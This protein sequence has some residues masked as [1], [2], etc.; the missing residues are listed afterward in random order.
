MNHHRSPETAFYFTIAGLLVLALLVTLSPG[1]NPTQLIPKAFASREQAVLQGGTWT[2]YA[3]GDAVQ[4]LAVQ[5]DYLWVGTYLGGLVRWDTRDQTYV[6]YLYPQSGLPSN[7]VRAVDI[8][9][10]GR[11]WVGTD[12]GLAVLSSNGSTIVAHHTGN[13]DLPVDDVTDVG[14]APD[15]K[16]WVA[17]DGGGVSVV[18][19]K[20]TTE[21]LS[22]DEWTVYGLEPL[23]SY[24]VTA[25]DFDEVGN[26]WIGTRPYPN[27]DPQGPPTLGG[28]VCIFDGRSCFTYSPL[29]SSM[30]STRVVTVHAGGGE[31]MWVGTSGGGVTLFRG[32]ESNQTFNKSN[33]GL[34]GNHV[35]AIARDAAGKMWFAVANAGQVGKGVTVLNG[36]FWATLTKTN[37]GLVSNNV[38]AIVADS[39]RRLWFGHRDLCGGVQ[40]VSALAASGQTWTTYD[41]TTSSIPS[42]RISSIAQDTRGDLWF[43]SD[44][45]GVLAYDRTLNRWRPYDQNTTGGG[46]PSNLVRDIAVDQAGRLWMATDSGGSVR[47]RRWTAYTGETTTGGLSNDD[48]HT[49][50]VDATG[51]VW[52]GHSQGIDQLDHQNTP[53]DLSD[54]LWYAFTTELPGLDVRD[55]AWVGGDHMWV[56]TDGGVGVYDGT[57]W[58][59]YRTPDLVSN[60]VQTIFPDSHSGQVWVGTANGASVFDQ[61]TGTWTSYT[62]ANTGGDLVDDNIQAIHVDSW[63]RVWFATSQGVSIKDGDEWSTFTAANS[64]L[65]ANDVTG[66]LVDG[67]GL[68]WLGTHEHGVSVFDSSDWDSFAF[69]DHGL[70][71]NYITDITFGADDSV[72][73]A[74][75]DRGFG[76]L[77]GA[78]WTTYSRASTEDQLASDKVRTIAIDEDSKAW[79]GTLSFISGGAWT[80]GGISVLDP[81]SGSWTTYDRDN[82]GS[83]GLQ[84][85]FIQKIAMD[86]AGRIWIGTGV[87]RYIDQCTGTITAGYGLTLYDHGSWTT[88][89]R[90]NTFRG[91]S[92]DRISDIAFDSQG[93]IWLATEP[94]PSQDRVGGVSRL[95]LGANGVP[96]PP[97]QG[98]D[99]WASWTNDDGSGLVAAP[100]GDSKGDLSSIHIDRADTAW[101][102][103]WTSTD[104]ISVHWRGRQGVHGSLNQFIGPRWM[105]HEPLPEAGYI[106]S[107]TSDAGDNLWVGTSWAGARYLD[108]QVWQAFTTAEYPLISN[109]INVVRVD[110]QGDVWFGTAGA[111]ISR[112]KPPPPTPTPTSTG[113][114][115]ETGTPTPTTTEMPTATVPP[116][117]TETPTPTNTLTG[118]ETDTPTATAT[119]QKTL[120]P[121]TTGVIETGTP[122]PT[123]TA[124]EPAKP[125]DTV[126][127]TPTGTPGR[128]HRLGLPMVLKGFFSQVL[129]PTATP[130]T[131]AQTVTAT[132]TPHESL[133]PM[134]SPTRTATVTPMVTQ[135]PTS[136]VTPTATPGEPFTPTPSPTRTQTATST[137]TQTSTS[138]VTLT[139]TPGESFTPTPSPTRTETAT[140]TVT[141]TPTPTPTPTTTGTETPTVTPTATPTVTQTPT[142]TASRTP[143]PTATGTETPTAT[144]TAGVPPSWHL[145]SSGTT[146]DLNDVFFVDPDTGWIVGEAGTILHSTG[147]GHMW[148]PQQTCKTGKDLYAVFFVDAN[149]GWVAGE[150]NTMCHTINGGASWSSQQINGVTNH[151]VMTLFM[152]SPTDGWAGT[153]AP[154]GGGAFL[155]YNGAGWSRSDGPSMAFEVTAIGLLTASDGWGTSATGHILRYSSSGWIHRTRFSLPLWDLDLLSSTDG[156]AVGD[157]NLVLHYDGSD[158]YEESRPR[159]NLY[160]VD[161]VSA[162]EGWA[163]GVSGLLLHYSDGSWQ[164]VTSP[165]RRVLKATQMWS[166]SLGWAV[167]E[168]GTVLRYGVPSQRHLTSQRAASLAVSGFWPCQ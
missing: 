48:L 147:G 104:E 2:T 49:V 40:G 76:V 138:T 90:A 57:G 109:D 53:H 8:D 64:G 101:A 152:L 122:S 46:L 45:R 105:A 23:P 82:T 140:P 55:I 95:D 29:N 67:W 134:P 85:N 63:R 135:T 6:Q 72:W 66:L 89:T 7:D 73:V 21:D 132:V 77:R 22:D 163:V 94:Y 41:I 81:K 96:D 75:T 28:G 44:G 153:I 114:P 164:E 51:K 108:D 56:A 165:T 168:L 150:A 38:T 14:I 98:D 31:Q 32:Q 136:T 24:V 166:G 61:E 47:S 111:G 130:S 167:G 84:G 118:R 100:K 157:K 74:T 129:T 141:G 158:W 50:A 148:S 93:R 161:M 69:A 128:V 121:T 68:I 127:P 13:S 12:R 162:D 154:G 144:A 37:S 119:V 1:L 133:T 26:V 54:D 126:T 42:E 124:T 99:V 156:W 116:T 97:R 3:N 58:T 143:S 137:V 160:G 33:S 79:V 123:A 35:S 16:V 139:A 107:I 151:D 131:T 15:G 17:T 65:V 4:A 27:P 52:F 149:E 155:R 115:T 19:D 43:G 120:T 59:A 117:A 9:G 92:S 78:T 146:R 88:Y 86:A 125:T 70:P 110:A 39:S 87:P 102:G 80:G 34:G 83:T 30:G 18:D 106:S 142:S 60:N 11:V 103:G 112:Y 20:G 36:G 25:L 5:G 159:G 113:T 62:T 91:L 10:L 145:V 71:S